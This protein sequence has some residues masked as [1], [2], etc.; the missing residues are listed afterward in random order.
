MELGYK[1]CGF[2]NCEWGGST[3][4]GIDYNQM[5]STCDS[6]AVT[7]TVSYAIKDGDTCIQLPGDSL[8]HPNTIDC[9]H[10]PTG[11]PIGTVC[12][13]LCALG[14]IISVAT[15]VVAHCKTGDKALKRSQPVYVYVFLMGSVALN[16]SIVSFV[17]ENTT[18]SCLGRIWS[19]NVAMTLMYGPLIMKLATIEKLVYLTKLKKVNITL[20]T[21][22]AEIAGLLAID[23]VILEF[24]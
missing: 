13:V 2:R 10:A 3:Q 8:R 5:V 22:L 14:C 6:T 11:S 1:Y 23:V 21:V 18:S 4:T 12:Y 19:Y 15:L 16:L 17:G 24:W 9:D 7:R 20:F